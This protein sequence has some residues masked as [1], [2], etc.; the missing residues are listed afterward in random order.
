M[1]KKKMFI[2]KMIIVTMDAMKQIWRE[3]CYCEN[4]GQVVELLL[5]LGKSERGF[6][7]T[8]LKS[9]LCWTSKRV[10]VWCVRISLSKT[11]IAHPHASSPFQFEN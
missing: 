7:I 8:C 9:V 1:M 4:E 2:T 3:I 11:W 5:S 6:A 10:C